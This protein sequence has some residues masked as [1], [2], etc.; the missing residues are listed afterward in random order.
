[1]YSDS[2]TVKDVLKFLKKE[3]FW[4]NSNFLAGESKARA[5]AYHATFSEYKRNTI[6]NNYITRIKNEKVKVFY[7]D[8]VE[9]LLNELNGDIEEGPRTW[10]YNKS[11]WIERVNEYYRLES[12]YEALIEL[13]VDYRT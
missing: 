3:Q 1:M 8:L 9:H 6:K 7:L 5:G 11:T 2:R 12:Y 10:I 13:G 4:R